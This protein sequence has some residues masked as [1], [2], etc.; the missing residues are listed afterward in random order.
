M[1]RGEPLN[2]G[3][4]I[5]LWFGAPSSTGRRFRMPALLEKLEEERLQSWNLWVFFSIVG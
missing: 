4:G 2:S 1:E 3:Q 5:Q